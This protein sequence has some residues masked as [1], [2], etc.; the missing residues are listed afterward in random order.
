[1]GLSLVTS[2]ERER[3][4]EREG[5]QLHTASGRFM[6]VVLPFVFS[7]SSYLKEREWWWEGYFYHTTGLHVN[8]MVCFVSREKLVI[9]S[10]VS[11]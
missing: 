4:R 2:R 8:K 11:C 9:G 1:M 6:C 5:K 10:F 7:F 3:E